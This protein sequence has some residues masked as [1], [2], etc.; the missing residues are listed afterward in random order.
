MADYGLKPIEKLPNGLKETAMACLLRTFKND[1]T[2]TLETA[3]IEFS[4]RQAPSAELPTV[5]T[6]KPAPRKKSNKALATAKRKAKQD[7]LALAMANG[8]GE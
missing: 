5:A 6:S 1:L 3:L 4:K 2:V 7:K 8:K